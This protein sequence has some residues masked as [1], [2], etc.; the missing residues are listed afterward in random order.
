M[1]DKQQGRLN[2]EVLMWFRPAHPY[3]S[4]PNWQSEAACRDYPTEL[5]Y[6]ERGAPNYRI[7]QAKQI[8]GDCPIRLKCLEYALYHNE[9]IGIWGGTSPEDRRILRRQRNDTRKPAARAR[10]TSRQPIQHGTYSGFAAHT[11]RKEQPCAECRNAKV[12]YDRKW[13]WKKQHGLT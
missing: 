13:R 5:F 4:D 3:D 2:A 10:T 11:R 1:V 9:T 12:E 8:C 6:P 7:V